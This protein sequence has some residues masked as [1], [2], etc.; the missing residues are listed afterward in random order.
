MVAVSLEPRP[1]APFRIRSAIGLAGGAELCR[2][3]GNQLIQCCVTSWQVLL[4][5]PNDSDVMQ[6]IFIRNL[7]HVSL[8]SLNDNVEYKRGVAGDRVR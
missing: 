1:L 5:I 3:C 4:F 6:K 8:R 2:N 7:I